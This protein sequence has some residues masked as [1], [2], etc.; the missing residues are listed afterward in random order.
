MAFTTRKG[1]VYAAHLPPRGCG[2]GMTRRI[3][4][5]QKISEKAQENGR[6]VWE[7]DF[8]A[9]FLQSICRANS[10]KQISINRKG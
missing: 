6:K 8:F 1:G 10:P 3:D 9:L 7:S 5:Q 2:M 4:G